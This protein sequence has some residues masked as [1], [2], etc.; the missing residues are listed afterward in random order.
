MPIP[1]DFAMCGEDVAV[2]GYS[3]ASRL[4][5]FGGRDGKGVVPNTLHAL[6]VEKG[7]WEVSPALFLRFEVPR[8]ELQLHRDRI[9][10]CWKW[11]GTL[12]RVPATLRL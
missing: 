4:V 10:R 9:H 2:T 5:V 1:T 7:T 11:E 3:I 12:T 6:D 8:K